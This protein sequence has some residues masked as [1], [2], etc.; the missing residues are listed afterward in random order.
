[1]TTYEIWRESEIK[2]VG[3]PLQHKAE[4]ILDKHA[5]QPTI[6][7]ADDVARTYVSMKKDIADV[8]LRRRDCSRRCSYHIVDFEFDSEG[9]VVR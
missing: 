4:A 1:M 5:A 2:R 8:M 7:L 3:A 6:E 9:Q